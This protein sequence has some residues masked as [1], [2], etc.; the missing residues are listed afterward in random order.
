MTSL[1]TMYPSAP[2]PLNHLRTNWSADPF[3]RQ[4]Y[5]YIGVGSTPS[6]MKI[7]AEP[8][9]DGKVFFAGEHT[10]FEFI[11]TAHTAYLSG[12][13]AANEVIKSV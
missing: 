12:V 1:K 4:T 2:N 8:T 3:S 6:D 7:L 13:R 11:G 5:S 10:N 9:P